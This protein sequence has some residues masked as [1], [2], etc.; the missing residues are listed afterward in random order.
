MGCDTCKQKNQSSKKKGDN[1]ETIDINFIPKSIQDGDYSGSFSIKLISFFVIIL[2]L[3]FIILVL[4]GQIFL[5]FF[6]PKSLPKVT[7]KIGEFFKGILKLY[8][9]FIY[10]RKLKKRKNQFE[11][12]R[13]YTT[14]PT[15]IEID[16]VELFDNKNIKK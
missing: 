10:N 7:K 8:G 15:G 5:Q 11:K 6:L 12:N 13:S 9:K 4:V 2:A 1:K 3:P 16:E 14:E